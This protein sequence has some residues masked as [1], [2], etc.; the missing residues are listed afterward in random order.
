MHFTKRA[1]AALA[2]SAGVIAAACSHDLPTSIESRAS[3]A[4]GQDPAITAQQRNLTELTRQVALALGDSLLRQHT[5]GDMKESRVTREHKLKLRSYVRGTGAGL[6]PAMARAS[7]RGSADVLAT[8]DGGRSLELYM[9]VE[10]HRA[11][12]TGGADLLVA[13]ALT[14]QSPL[15]AF[16]LKGEPV[17]LDRNA[18]PSTPTLVLNTVE[19]DFDRP[20]PDSWKNTDNK[21]GKAIG[22]LAR[23]TSNA[24]AVAAARNTRAPGT[25]FVTPNL[26]TCEDD[27]TQPDCQ[28]PDTSLPPGLYL[29]FSHIEDLGESW[30]RG[31]PEIEVHLIG[32]TFDPNNDGE[33]LSCTAATVAQP[34]FFDQNNHDWHQSPYGAWEGQLFSK[35][36]IE[37][38]ND[39]YN[40]PFVIQFWE[41]DDESCL[42]K[43]N[44]LTGLRQLAYNLQTIYD[45]TSVAIEIVS[46]TNWQVLVGHIESVIDR[47]RGDDHFLGTAIRQENVGRYYPDATHVLMLGDGN[48]APP[49]NGRIHLRTITQ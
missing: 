46:N 4:P 45:A 49:E 14:E 20:L 36:N 16:N 31:D 32:P 3:R 28:P 6:V 22:T 2:I 39:V 23:E 37:A 38:Y 47:L 35:A 11:S 33:H 41:D 40:K 43:Q 42:I 27:P 17:T 7:G 44:G 1:C 24:P 29:D 30:W 5:L 25:Q 10:A 9:P 26:R 21:S 8:I 48:G 18:P 12:W 15:V 19:S 13:S 34:K